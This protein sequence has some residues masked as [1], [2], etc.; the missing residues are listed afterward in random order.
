MDYCNIDIENCQISGSGQIQENSGGIAGNAFG[1][2]SVCTI[3]NCSN[4]IGVAGDY[5][6]GICGSAAGHGGTLTIT[7]YLDGNSSTACENSGDITGKE[8]G[9]ICGP[10][11]GYNSGTVT[12]S[13]CT[14]N[15][16]IGVDNGGICG[17]YASHMG[18][19]V[20]ISYW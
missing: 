15:G 7:E 4:S 12:I 11:V 10:G 6:G 17:P 3:K 9:G 5:S 13:N 19:N 20:L 14:N 2:N 8:C 16:E 1:R 18:G